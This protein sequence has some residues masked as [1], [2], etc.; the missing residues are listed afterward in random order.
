ML[1]RIYAQAASFFSGLAC[2]LA[3]FQVHS[4]A[5]DTVLPIV[6]REKQVTSS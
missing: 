1:G 2:P 4:L 6:P 5:S 3:L